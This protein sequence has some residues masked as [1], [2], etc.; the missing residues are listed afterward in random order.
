[1]LIRFIVKNLFS[2]KEETEF[3]L[4]PGRATRL[5]HHKYERGGLSILKQTAIY[6]ANGSGKSNLVK[7]INALQSMIRTGTIPYTINSQRFKL[8]KS[9][10]EEP[11]ELGI[12]FYSSITNKIY[13]YSIAINNGIITDEYLGESG[14]SKDRLI[15]NRT[16]INKSTII[17]FFEGFDKNE[18]NIVLKEVIEKNLIKPNQPLVFLLN[19]ITDDAFFDAREAWIWITFKLVLIGKDTHASGA[20]I[21][22]IDKREDFRLFAKELMCSFNT[23]INDLKIGRGPIEDYVGKENERVMNE[24]KSE[25]QDNPKE[26]RF[27][28]HSLSNESISI[29]NEDDKVIVKKLLFLHKGEKNET[30]DFNYI[31]ESDGTQR[32]LEFI[33]VFYEIINKESTYIVDEMETSLHPTIIKELISK[34]SHDE[35]TKGQLIFTT[36]ESNLLDQDIF[37][38][39]EIWFAEKGIN[40]ATK[41]YS[42]SDFKEHNTIDIRKGYLSGRYGAI[43]FLGNLH[44]L[45]WDKK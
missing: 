13:F 37:R 9:N 7:A 1:M 39:D 41:L 6:G 23:G 38:T 43:P 25:L 19:E 30:I 3:N 45:N 2:F 35:H 5:N 34:F 17:N 22:A 27:L 16:I 42:L 26:V 8:A 15:F 44:D 14:I 33:P 28:P 12:E 36:H 10:Q 11:V 21:E 29:V 4:L 40:G 32:L 18:K 20:I 31:E 24:I